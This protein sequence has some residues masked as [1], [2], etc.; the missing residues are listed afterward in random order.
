LTV[1]DLILE[2]QD[3]DPTL[4]VRM[5][6]ANKSCAVVNSVCLESDDKASWVLLDDYK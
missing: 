4:E 5:E 3:L 1:E 2:L 6:I